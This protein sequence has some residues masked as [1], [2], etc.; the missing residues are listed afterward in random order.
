MAAGVV[1]VGFRGMTLDDAPWVR[2][3][4]AAGLGGVILFDRDQRIGNARNVESPKQVRALTAELA[5]LR[6]SSPLIVSIDQEGGV[7][8]RLSPAHGFPALDSERDVGAGSVKAARSWAAGLAGTLADAGITLDLAPVVDL[9][10][11]RRSPVIGALGR[12]FSADPDVVVRYATIEVEAL[13]AA[14]VASALKHFP[15]IGSS[16]RNTDDDSVDVTRTWTRHELEPFRR[17]VAD[18]EADVVMVGHVVNRT[19]DPDRPA[20]LSPAIIGELLR[21]E[22]VWDGP[23]ITDDLGAAAITA[24]HPAPAAAVLALEA[25]ADLLLFANQRQYDAGIPDKVVA[26][27]MKAVDDGRLDRAVVERAYARVKQR[28]SSSR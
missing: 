12:A 14:G 5:A 21:D 10:V 13:R 19:L 22:L 9:D 27:I 18:G 23:V 6:P 4:A 25:G 26:A 17:L 24:L 3:A 20:S 7:V 28:F 15:G 1:I 11:N 2:D 8:S 16:T